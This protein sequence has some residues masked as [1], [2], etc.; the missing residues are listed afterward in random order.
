MTEQA[1]LF[2][3]AGPSPALARCW[4][5]R[6]AV[7][8]SVLSRWV[9]LVRG[10]VRSARH[11]IVTLLRP[12]LRRAGFDLWPTPCASERAAREVKIKRSVYN[13]NGEHHGWSLAAAVFDAASPDPSRRWPETGHRDLGVVGHRVNSVWC[14]RLMGYPTGWVSRG[15]VIRRSRS[16]AGAA[17]A[18]TLA[19]LETL[20]VPWML[21]KEFVVT[22]RHRTVPVRFVG[23]KHGEGADGLH[24]TPAARIEKTA[25]VA[26]TTRLMGFPDGWQR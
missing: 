7:A 18:T 26:W 23:T 11:R 14:E 16:M 5:K 17:C 12:D 6:V 8:P 25:S 1:A 22:S 24:R 21:F 9:P 20:D 10:S 13:Q 3:R 4:G 19:R 15:D 2:P